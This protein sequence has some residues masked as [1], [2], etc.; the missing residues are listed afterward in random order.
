MPVYAARSVLVSPASGTAISTATGWIPTNIHE[1]P[2]NVGFGVVKNGGGDI[3]FRVEHT[4]D[5]VFDSSVTPTVF[6]HDDVSANS[7]DVDGNY[8][9]AV[10]AIRLATVSA[11]GSVGATLTVIQAG[12]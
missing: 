4:F 5:D 10:R 7:A 9:Y 6:V 8:A 11:S 2:F 12:V 3:T 1:T